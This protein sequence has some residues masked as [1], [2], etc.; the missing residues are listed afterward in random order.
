MK[1]NEFRLS[2][3]FTTTKSYDLAF[4]VL[5]RMTLGSNLLDALDVELSWT[6]N[7][8]TIIETYCT[9]QDANYMYAYDCFVAD[10]QNAL[11]DGV[12]VEEDE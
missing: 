4:E 3:Y 2:D 10:L 12:L 6:C 1:I 8:W 11:N 9:P 7:E 5:D